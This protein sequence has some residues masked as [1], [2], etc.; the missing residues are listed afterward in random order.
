MNVFKKMQTYQK[1]KKI[2]FFKIKIVLIGLFLGIIIIFL[3]LYHLQVHEQQNLHIL[4][5]KNCIKTEVV[6]PL[7][8]NFFDTKQ[9]LL[10]ANRPVFDLYWHGPGKQWN[11]EICQPILDKIL[12]IIGPERIHTEIGGLRFAHKHGLRSLLKSDL[13]FDE[14]CKVSEQCSNCDFLLVKNR[15]DRIYP[16]KTLA[17]HLLGYLSRSEK[18]GCSGLEQAFEGE[19]KGQPGSV[20]AMT[21]SVGRQ[22]TTETMQQSQPGTD[23][24]LTLDFELQSIAESMFEPGQ[25]GA[26]ILMDAATGGLKVFL[27]YPNFDPNIFLGQISAAT[28]DAT[29]GTNN[30]LLNRITRAQYPPASIFKIAT[31]SAAIDEGLITPETQFFCRGYVEFCGRKYFCKRRTGHGSLPAVDG[32]ATSCNAHC[33]EIAKMIKIDTLA[34]YA[35]RF[36]LGLKTNF[37]LPEKTGLIPTA[38]WKKRVKKEPWW[39]G[40]T[41][42]AS[43]GQSYLLVTPIQVARMIAG[44][45]TGK[46][47]KPRALESEPIETCPVNVSPRAL[48]F[49]RSGMKKV[50]HIG[51]GRRLGFLKD[52]DCYFKTGTAQN[53]SLSVEKT[54]RKFF[55]HGWVAGYFK[56]KDEA[57]M[58]LVVLLEHVET[59]TVAVELGAR[60]LRSYRQIREMSRQEKAPELNE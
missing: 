25:S 19:L 50:V 13:S 40:E 27:S 17:S 51:T 21:D 26:L 4:G 46:L 49:L 45:A 5:K 14:L 54:E 53:V 8:G 12:V 48:N 23:L 31:F 41:L 9:V 18:I 1:S 37:L 38:A 59:S 52:F 2:R 55:E 7:R 34:D 10:A 30:P 22:L 20:N 6:P 44:I 11:P 56:Y 24:K 33:F 15:F 29:M 42:S 3:R 58:V 16:Y 32:L 57:P 35:T 39:A 60:F 28:W 36:G 47:V 43:I